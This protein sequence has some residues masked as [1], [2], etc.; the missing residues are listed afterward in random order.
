MCHGDRSER[1]SSPGTWGG[2]ELSKDFGGP[3]RTQSATSKATAFF[4]TCGFLLF[5]SEHM[6]GL[7]EHFS[8]IP[9]PHTMSMWMRNRAGS[10]LGF[11]WSCKRAEHSLVEMKLPK[12][13]DAVYPWNFQVTGHFTCACNSTD[14]SLGEL[15]C[16]CE[17][18][19]WYKSLRMIPKAAA[20]KAF[21]SEFS[22]C[23]FEGSAPNQLYLKAHT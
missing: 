12:A 7:L 15:L 21:Q 17:L 2:K 18:W 22:I 16:T 4:T 8:G 20:C 9:L 3:L 23:C 1:P 19:R 14:L 11:A 5:Q 10:R 6:E 13:R